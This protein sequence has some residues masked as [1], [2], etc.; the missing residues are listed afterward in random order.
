MQ[1]YFVYHGGVTPDNYDAS[2]GR[3]PY[4][5]DVCETEN[6]VLDLRKEHEDSLDR[7]TSHPI[8]RV[9]LGDE[10]TMLPEQKVT[11]WKLFKI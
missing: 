11:T 5:L 1:K 6:E 7:E 2:E 8:F 4:R 10:L 9:F 3:G